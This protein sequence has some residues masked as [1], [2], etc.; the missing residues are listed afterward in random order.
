MT[1]IQRRRI[2]LVGL[3]DRVLW[4]LTR[5]L[6]LWD[7]RIGYDCAQGVEEALAVCG[8]ERID[9]LVLDSPESAARAARLFKDRDAA[10]R[11]PPAWLVL[12]DEVPAGGL[13]IPGA[14]RSTLVVER[15]VHP[16]EF[17]LMVLKAFSGIEPRGVAEKR[18]VVLGQREGEPARM[19]AAQEGWPRGRPAMFPEE[20]YAGPP[21]PEG[22][23]AERA[24][25]AAPE[26]EP[27]PSAGFYVLLAKGFECLKIQDRRGAL[28]NWKAALA[29]K[30][31]D[32]RL[33]ANIARL[34]GAEE[35]I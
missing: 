11:C 15:P 14:P 27:P 7:E 2:L 8:R 30:P 10:D 33:K 20:R 28:E 16:K 1:G 31:D 23:V 5:T 6:A 32:R 21:A 26:A 35:T 19:P 4:Q 29:L 24:A 3:D 18:P 34:E 13:L 9:L 22:P 17:P 25:P 12:A